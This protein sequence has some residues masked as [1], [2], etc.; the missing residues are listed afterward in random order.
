MRFS[1]EVLLYFDESG[2]YGFP[3]QGVRGDLLTDRGEPRVD[4]LA[5]GLF[6][7]RRDDV[8]REV[9][10]RPALAARVHKCRLARLPCSTARCLYAASSPPRLPH[11]SRSMGRRQLDSSAW[12]ISGLERCHL[13][14]D[15]VRISFE[16]QQANAAP[17]RHDAQLRS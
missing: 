4:P 5:V 12:L 13:A 7:D 16:P 14:W 11:L 9:V 15:V 2:D 8:L 17:Q 3:A 1:L 6:Q 10:A